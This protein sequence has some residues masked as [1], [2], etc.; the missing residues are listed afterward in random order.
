MADMTLQETVNNVGSTKETSNNSSKES[1]QP[2]DVEGAEP[3]FFIDTDGNQPIETGLPP[4]V[5]RASSPTPSSSGDDILLFAGRDSNGR[6]IIRSPPNIKAP[7]TRSRNVRTVE[8]KIN[9]QS[10]AVPSASGSF[11][12]PLNDA[13]KAVHINASSSQGP[14]A[15][16][17]ESL[18]PKPKSRHN[19]RSRGFE[20]ETSEDDA[21][22]ADYIANLEEQGFDPA[23]PFGQ[24][25][26]GGFDD[27]WNGAEDSSESPGKDESPEKDA[28][29]DWN[30]SDLS[31]FNNLSTSDGVL[32]IVQAVLSKRT[33]PSGLQY[34]V[35]WENQTVDEAR[36]IHT[37]N[38]T[39]PHATSL[40]AKFEAE[41]KV[42]A[43]LYADADDSDS[44]DDML[45]IEND[46]NDSDDEDDAAIE[47]L[48][49]S[50][51][52]MADA[53][54]ARLLAKQEELGMGSDELMIFDGLTGAPD[55]EDSFMPRPS[56]RMKPASKRPQGEIPAA[57]L[58]ADAYDGFDVMD[59]ERPSLK[60]KPKG[61]RGKLPFDISDSELELSRQAAW[62]N[63]R[64]K[65]K[66]RKEERESL[67]LQGLLGRNGKKP[68]LKAKYKE[69]MGIHAVK[70]EI[71]MFL[72][73][74]NTTYVPF[75]LADFDN[76]S[77]MI[78]MIRPRFI[79]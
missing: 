61:R 14:I 23:M 47:A 68:D 37:D 57:S 67:R 32:G 74:G 16:E 2:A 79:L 19:K 62:D 17:T 27:V 34:L 39:N 3:S 56:R 9:L 10:E 58:L 51:D 41:E 35:V 50:I 28:A 15:E 75:F 22:I 64:M 43:D 30:R 49:Q 21:L 25:T 44:D 36:W 33:R 38:L 59:F 55:N 24:R 60:R 40:I 76:S 72:M 26:L 66:E 7:S 73:G 18:A 42:L 46:A 70:D 11:N 1:S 65:K 4:P 45:D 77:W 29:D 8:D 52:K 78:Y 5:I 69:G 71:K 54:I 53:E 48:K 20:K 13:E 31:D 12:Q 6:G 63:D